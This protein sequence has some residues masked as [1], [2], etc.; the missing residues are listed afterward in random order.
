MSDQLFKAI[1]NIMSDKNKESRKL[2]YQITIE[3][4]NT[5]PYE[6][7]WITTIDWLRANRN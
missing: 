3:L 7:D 5:I 1:A 2:L 4:V 6:P